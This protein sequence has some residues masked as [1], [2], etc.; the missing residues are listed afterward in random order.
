MFIVD[1]VYILVGYVSLVELIVLVVYSVFVVGVDIGFIYMGMV[2]N[3]FII[4]MFGLICLYIK[5]DN[6]DI[7]VIYKELFCVFCKWK[8][9]CVGI[10]DCM[11]EIFF[12]DIIVIIRKYLWFYVYCILN[13]VDIF[14]EELNKLFIYLMF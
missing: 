2:Y 5:I 12:E 4:V 14:M 11:W 1:N 6:L 8:F 3:K 7:Y 10:Y 13:L 9:I